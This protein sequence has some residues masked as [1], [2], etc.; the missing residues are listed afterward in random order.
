MKFEELPVKKFRERLFIKQSENLHGKTEYNKHYLDNLPEIVE[1]LP[2]FIAWES[3]SVSW[4]VLWVGLDPR[5]LKWVLGRHNSPV[6][7]IVSPIR[8]VALDDR[9]KRMLITHEDRK[10]IDKIEVPFKEPI[11][12]SEEDRVISESLSGKVVVDEPDID[13]A[14]RMIEKNMEMLNNQMAILK[15]NE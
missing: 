7:K 3:F 15:G 6:R 2:G 1:A 13:K 11:P 12:E 8:I 4:D 5:T 10:D 14:M 9:S